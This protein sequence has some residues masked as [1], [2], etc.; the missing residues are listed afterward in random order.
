MRRWTSRLAPVVAV[1]VVL[2]AH[3][4]MLTPAEALIHEII[5][6]LCREGGE[7]VVPPGQANPALHAFTRALL[8]TGFIVS[9]DVS[10]TEVVVTFDPTVPNSKFTSAGFDQTIPDG[11]AP[12]VDLVLSPLVIPDESFPAH[13]HC[14]NLNP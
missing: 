11:I 5:A 10:E 13:E 7:E 12:G 4:S 14:R 1:A 9:V 3:L 2:V 6:A 8:A